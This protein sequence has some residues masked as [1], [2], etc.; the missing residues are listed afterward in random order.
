[1]STLASLADIEIVSLTWAANAECARVYKNH[2]VSAAINHVAVTQANHS[3]LDEDRRGGFSREG[4]GWAIW[5]SGEEGEVTLHYQGWPLKPPV[6]ELP[7]WVRKMYE[8]W[9][10]L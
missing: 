1:M 2:V 4:A 3:R 7:E 5:A 8:G 6:R 10:D 9:M